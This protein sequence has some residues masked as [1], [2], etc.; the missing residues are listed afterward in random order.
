MAEGNVDR[1]VQ[2]A[3]FPPPHTGRSFVDV[4]AARPDY[5][6]ISSL[7]R[8]L[9]WRVIAIE[10]NPAFAELHR[11]RGFEVLQYACGDHDEDD[12]EFFVVDSHG[13]DYAGGRVS[14]ESFSSLGI[15]EPLVMIVENLFDSHEYRSRLAARGYLRW[16]KIPPNE[17]YVREDLAARVLPWHQRLWARLRT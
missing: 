12:V 11:E 5:L 9:G 17:V 10:P 2:E 1:L 16:R 3:F 15:K 13:A 8:S 6:S 4:G 7:Y 14:F